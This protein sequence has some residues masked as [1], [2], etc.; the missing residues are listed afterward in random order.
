MKPKKVLIIGT[1]P[2]GCDMTRQFAEMGCHVEHCA[3][4]EAA[5]ALV[6]ECD[7]VCVL[8][9]G[10]GI[11]SRRSTAD[12]RAI[13]GL[14]VLASHIP[15]GRKVV[16]HLLLHSNTTLWLLR[17]NELKAEVA[18]K[19]DV[20]PFTI[21]DVWSRNVVLDRQP[22]NVGDNRVVH[23]VIVGSGTM[24]ECVAVNAALTA[25]YP[26]YTRDHCL[27]TRIT[28]VDEHAS[29]L[30]Q[31][32]AE[33]YKHLADNSYYRVVKPTA[34]QVVTEFHKP[35]YAATREDFVDVEWE[36]VEAS[37]YDSMVR[38][39]F[40]LWSKNTSGQLLTIVMAHASGDR[41][42]SEALYLPDAVSAMNVPVYV[43]MRHSA[44][45]E[46]VAPHDKLNN[47]IPIGMVDHG[48]DMSLP[49]VDMAKTINYIYDYCYNENILNW[50]GEMNFA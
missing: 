43:T 17:S 40:Q 39:K 38:E 37:V 36:W 13:A 11:E 19:L 3:D 14:D 48:Y 45:L 25:H 42:L 15:D 12:S 50:T 23:L 16:C 33:R 21:D 18:N 20:Y 30:C 6:G 32:W 28:V 24:A 26:N 35:K 41:N 44:L 9:Q 22:I 47:L 49:L 34:A 5:S 29:R 4:V 31:V 8:S 46:N 2:I 10:T 27:R 1:H 7:E